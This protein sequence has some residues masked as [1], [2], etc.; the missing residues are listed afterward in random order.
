MCENVYHY[1]NFS[2]FAGMFAENFTGNLWLFDARQMNDKSEIK[3]FTDEIIRKTKE[4]LSCETQRNSLNDVYHQYMLHH[5]TTTYVMSFSS[6]H[7]DASQWQIYGNK[8]AGISI[9]FNKHYLEEFVHKCC[10]RNCPGRL[11]TVFYFIPK[12]HELPDILADF[13]KTGNDST[14][15]FENLNEAI[16]CM[17][18]CGASFK[19]PSFNS[20]VETR[21]AITWP[22]KQSN[23]HYQ[24]TPTKIKKYYCLPWTKCFNPIPNEENWID[25]FNYDDLITEILIG[26]C[27][28]QSIDVLKEYLK[29]HKFE[30][31]ADK[32]YKS[33][34]PLQV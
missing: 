20:E 12:D 21:I 11:Q 19:D 8:G 32:V 9:G 22:I 25:N 27:S 2:S 24:C 5:E 7:D 1:T 28:T 29:D 23:V 30:K 13:M 3:K 17:F 16:Q 14:H 15:T 18:A 31:L 26:P 33:K 34:C 10:L 4:I 6:K